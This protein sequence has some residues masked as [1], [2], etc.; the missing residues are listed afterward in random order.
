MKYYRKLAL[1][2]VIIL[3][4]TVCFPGSIYAADIEKIDPYSIMSSELVE[5]LDDIESKSKEHVGIAV[6]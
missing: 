3:S 4:L 6:W 5:F 1:T 2:I